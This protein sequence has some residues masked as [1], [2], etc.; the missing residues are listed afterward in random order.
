MDDLAIGRLARAL[1]H[2]LGIRQ[3][4][5]GARARMS[6]DL[7]SYVER[8]RLDR[9]P[10]WRLRRIFAVFDAD[11]VIVVRWRG[12]DLDRLVDAA[13][14]QLGELM[15][16]RL[17]EDGWE[18]HPEVSFS[19]FGERGSIDLLAWHSSS[20]TL[21]VVELKTEIASVEETLRVHDMKCRL[22]PKIARQRYGW[23]VRDVGR[24]LV[25]P[26]ARTPRDRVHRHAAL[27]SRAY[28][29][30]TVAVRRWL[31]DPRSSMSGLIFLRTTTD[32]RHRP[33]APSRKRIRLPRS[34]APERGSA[35][36]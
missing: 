20:R 2:R 5:V 4:D 11:V 19:E 18:V 35:D 26:D 23:D 34:R 8:G 24:L 27:F 14:A 13:H 28:A 21:L 17:R 31:R 16:R 1:R 29:M 33:G 22:A 9:L 3:R 25:L 12:G 30:R 36:A 6:Q 7:V 15:T 32:V 10:L